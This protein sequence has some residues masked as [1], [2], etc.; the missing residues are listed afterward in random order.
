[1]KKKIIIASS[2][3]LVLIVVLSLCLTTGLFNFK[4]YSGISTNEENSNHLNSLDSVVYILGD[5]LDFEFEI[6]IKKIQNI[7]E[8]EMDN[9]YV[10][11]IFNDQK[12]DKVI[13][14]EE[15]ELLNSKIADGL[16]FFY[17]GDNLIS[18]VKEQCNISNIVDNQYGILIYEAIIRESKVG[19]WTKQ[20]FIDKDIDK[21][22]LTSRIV[23]HICDITK[24]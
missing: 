15:Y 2:I 21:Y 5:D 8:V 23:K 10:T 13:T 19:F 24:L 6:N 20:N 11:L 1:M 3:T 4:Q 9:Q 17:L 12:S 18:E 14:T 22:Y 7:N 16:I